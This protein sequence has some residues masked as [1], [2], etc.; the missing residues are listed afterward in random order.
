MR[1]LPDHAQRERIRCELDRNLMV[2]S[3]AGS[4]KTHSMC[5]R[6]VAGIVQGRY[7]VEHMVAVTFTRK[8]AA[9]LRGRLQ[10]ALEA[11]EAREVELD[12]MFIGTI[13][14]FCARLLREAP[15]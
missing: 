15:V 14:S 9:E 12:R 10:L 4:G 3:P 13:H 8:A 6:M 7:R 11:V 5:A 2:E 1:V